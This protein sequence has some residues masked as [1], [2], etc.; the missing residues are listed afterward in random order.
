[1]SA[2]GEFG[3]QVGASCHGGH[4]MAVAH[5]FTH[6]HEVGND[7]MTLETPHRL[8]HA[9]KTRLHL[10]GDKETAGS[11]HVTH[12]SGEKPGRMREHAIAGENRIRE[13]SSKTHSIG[14]HT[15]D[16]LAYAL[17]ECCGIVSAARRRHGVYTGPKRGA[18]L[19][20][21]TGDDVGDA[22][23]GELSDDESGAPGHR[24]GYPH[25]QIIGLAASACEYDAPELPR[26]G[27]QQLLGE[28]QRLLGQI[29]G[30]GIESTCLTRQRVDDPGVAVPHDWNVV[31][32]VQISAAVLVIHPHSLGTDDLQRLL[33]EEPVGR[34][35]QALTACQDRRVVLG[36]AVTR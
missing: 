34:G 2:L 36:G 4:G 23:V 8:T 16:A 19:G 28:L 12:G 21:H 26:Q 15:L 31:I 10:V 33:I 6:R 20:R 35:E 9:A 22:V 30:M 7:A 32:G 13:E 18:V 1:M 3:K 5:R 14:L 11:V 25:R 27:A 24:L 17:A 29:A